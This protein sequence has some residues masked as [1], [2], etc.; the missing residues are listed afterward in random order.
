MPD[1]LLFVLTFC[2]TPGSGLA[3]GLF[4]A[5]SAFLMNPLARRGLARCFL[6]RLGWG[7][8]F[9]QSSECRN[10]LSGQCACGERLKRRR[11]H[12]DE[13]GFAHRDLRQI[14]GQLSSFSCSTG[15]SAP[16]SSPPSWFDTELSITFASFGWLSEPLLA[17]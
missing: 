3:A 15:S 11:L 6:K 16:A 10:H 9:T 2:S 5:F 13:L 8:P 4:F 7:K 17:R 1:R 14:V 12:G